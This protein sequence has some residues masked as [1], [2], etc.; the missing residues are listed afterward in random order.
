MNQF[1]SMTPVD[2]VNAGGGTLLQGGPSPTAAMYSET[3]RSHQAALA[4]MQAR[5]GGGTPNGQ[6]ANP[7][8]THRGR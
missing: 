5:Y 3:D 2:S 1:Q 4:M 8:P 6:Y 7:A